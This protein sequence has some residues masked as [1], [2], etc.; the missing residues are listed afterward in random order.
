MQKD[1]AFKVKSISC[2]CTGGSEYLVERYL[3]IHSHKDCIIPFHL[4]VQYLYFKENC[5]ISLWWS[6]LNWNCWQTKIHQWKSLLCGYYWNSVNTLCNDQRQFN[7]INYLN[8]ERNQY[9]GKKRYREWARL[10][11]SCTDKVRT[12]RMAHR[13]ALVGGLSPHW[14]QQKVNVINGKKS[15][16]KWQ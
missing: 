14:K 6:T 8:A 3:H 12:G 9:T 10:A 13:G 16:H 5:T 15:R 4:S 11:G 1:K 7:I 2:I